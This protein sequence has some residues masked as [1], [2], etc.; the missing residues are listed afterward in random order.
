LGRVS[1][2]RP[3]RPPELK[4]RL[5]PEEWRIASSIVFSSKLKREKFLGI[6]SRVGGPFFLVAPGFVLLFTTWSSTLTVPLLVADLIGT[7]IVPVYGALIVGPFL[8]RMRLEAD[9][10]AARQVGR[11][12]MLHTLEKIKSLGLK[13]SLAGGR[14]GTRPTLAE[15]IKALQQ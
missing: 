7:L 3:G 14:T 4:G 11:E 1:H 12:S 6:A 5:E 8:R 2:E 13:D 10:L 9:R 15:R